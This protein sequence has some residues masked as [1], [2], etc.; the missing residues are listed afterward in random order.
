MSLFIQN[1]RVGQK[2]LEYVDEISVEYVKK[3]GQTFQPKHIKHMKQK[4]I[5]HW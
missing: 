4:I 5:C 1:K 3:G 2:K